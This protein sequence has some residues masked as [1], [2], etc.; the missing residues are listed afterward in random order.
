MISSAREP[1]EEDQPYRTIEVAGQ[2][3]G[4][5]LS[6]FLARQGTAELG[7]WGTSLLGGVDPDAA[8]REYQETNR[9]IL[10]YGA[11]TLALVL[12]TGLMVSAWITRPIRR[13]TEAS[14]AVAGGQLD[15][16]VPDSGRDELA[17]LARAFNSM[18]TEIRDES[19]YRSILGR[20][21]D[22]ES[23]EQLQKTLALT[24]DLS[25]GQ[26]LRASVLSCELRGHTTQRTSS[27]PSKV[28]LAV[29]QVMD[30]LIPILEA[31]GGI[32][33]MISGD[34]VLAHFG[35]LPKQLPIQVSALQATHAG[36]EALN[37]LY[38]LN[39]RRTAAGLN[40]LDLG[41]GVASGWAIAGGV[42]D[43]DYLR[44]TV[45]GETVR[46][47]ERIMEATRN[48]GGSV[49]LIS[50]TV[51]ENLSGGRSDFKFGRFGKASIPDEGKEFGIYEVAGRSS[52]LVDCSEI[53]LDE[54]PEWPLEE[55]GSE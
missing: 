2:R 54:S 33:M 12:L 52:Q 1:E 25:T 47:A 40:A 42:G 53:E 26:Q 39:E 22:P 43:S 44:Y 48:I 14:T 10:Q 38:R 24:Q 28:M 16:H 13:L 11:I 41:I 45:V 46:A 6:P 49:V 35:V 3:Y 51:H 21:P 8:Y 23:K 30:G 4:E 29:N 37:F 34:R 20:S 36:M 55:D 50:E 7:I 5:V 19:L 9:I 15:T 31:H 18:V 17:T 27:D 32:L